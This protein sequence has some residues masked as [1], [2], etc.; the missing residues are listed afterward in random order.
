MP[1]QVLLH[2]GLCLDEPLA[3]VLGGFGDHQ[4]TLPSGVE[5]RL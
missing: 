2:L 5:F 3:F 4:C 1:E